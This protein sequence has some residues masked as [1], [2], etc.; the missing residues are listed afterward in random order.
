MQFNSP[1]S[2]LSVAA[3]SSHHSLE[4]PRWD[5]Q[6]RTLF[7]AGHKI[8][9]FKQPAQSQE[10]ILIA[11]QEDGWPVRIDDPLPPLAG[12]DQHA[13]KWRLRSTVENLNRAQ[14]GPIRVRFLL[15]GTGQ[16]VCWSIVGD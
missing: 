12:K 16:G 14:H 11:F 8:K 10:L 5:E 7:V 1:S 6:R 9:Q 15:D 4:A 13:I 3:D 2:G